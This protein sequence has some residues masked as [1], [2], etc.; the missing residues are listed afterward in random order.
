MFIKIHMPIVSECSD[1]TGLW[2]QKRLEQLLFKI[3][4]TQ[5]AKNKWVEMGKQL[6]SRKV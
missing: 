3:A 1:E 6:V 2:M 4:C 5:A